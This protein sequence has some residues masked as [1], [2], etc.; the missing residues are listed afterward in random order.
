M[1]GFAWALPLAAFACTTSGPQGEAGLGDVR[2]G[3]PNTTSSLPNSTSPTS[4]SSGGK[5]GAPGTTMLEGGVPAMTSGTGAGSGGIA[6]NGGVPGGGGAGELGTGGRTSDQAGQTSAGAGS[7]GVAPSRGGA[8][9]MQ[10]GGT[11]P[12]GG[13]GT[14]ATAGSAGFV[15]NWPPSATFSNP[16]IWQDLADDEVI[17]VDDTYYYT[18]SNM[19]YSPGAPILRSYDLVNWEYAGHAIPTLD[20]SAKYDLT[21]GQ[22]YI[23]GTWASTLQY[24]KSNKTFYW[25]GC[26]E[27]GKTYVYTASAVEGPWQ[28][29]PP[30]NNC[31]ND[32]GMLVD[33][34][35]TL[36]VA[37]G[38]T[39]ISVA[40]LGADGFTQ[41][42]TQQVYSA[43][44]MT[45]EG[46]HFLKYQGNYYITLTRPADGEFVL[47]S[48]SPWGPYTI[49]AL[50][51][52]NASPIPGGG[53]PHQGSLV[54]TQS[55]D[56][57]YMAFVDAYPGGR[58]PVLA[59]V[60]WS[61]DGWP[62]VQLVNGGWAASYP[63]PKVP[64][65]PRAMRPLTGTQTFDGPTLGHEW[66]WNH[67][68]DN[69]KWSFDGG[70]KLQTATVTTDLYRA[71]NTLT[72][73]I[74]GPQSTGTIQLD[75]SGMQDGDVAGLALL[76]Q[77]SAYIA[78]KK[79]GG[80][81][82]IVV[83]NGLSMDSKWNTASTGKEAASAPLTGNTVWLRLAADIRP[84][85][86]RQGKFSYSTDGS[87]FTA[88]GPGCN[89]N[90]S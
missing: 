66:E 68:P 42:K 50:I 35:D 63:Y 27:F 20:F 28:K 19:H 11:L 1:L 60:T 83:F 71:R 77:D 47:K 10:T 88:L 41:V 86:G 90:N 9:G 12:N 79:S 18:A 45:L 43:T 24:R 59:P 39:Q 58:V 75:I 53:V 64:R 23:K 76:R 82:R 67:N 6:A 7:G 34:D 14:G 51:D 38:N 17:R 44:G 72:H 33:D 49:R 31:Y 87:T 74:L 61:A 16:V 78:V 55:G 85:S 21:Q 69:T 56:W 2:G 81:A 54:Q 37:Y 84:G 32:A 70:L 36:Y 22:A 48:S 25:L 57:Y 13:G 29:H 30:I 15:G 52:R 5:G 89:M 73:R 8:S 4:S 3:S 62:S 26:I 40:Q 65:P 46:S 80:S